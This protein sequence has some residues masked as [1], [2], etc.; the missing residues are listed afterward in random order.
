MSL[1]GGGGGADS[2]SVVLTVNT[3]LHVLACAG[4]C[5]HVPTMPSK[6]GVPKTIKQ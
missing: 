4:M 6:P 3:T 1:G 5:W 2:N